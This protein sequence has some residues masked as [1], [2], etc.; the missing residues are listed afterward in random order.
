MNETNIYKPSNKFS[1]IGIIL[2]LFSM[3]AVGLILSWLYLILN[4]AI[5][6]IYLNVILAAGVSFGLGAIG[7]FFVKVYKI[8]APKLALIVSL[9]ALL[10]VNYGK[11]AIY[12]GRDYDKYMYE[13]LKDTK[14]TELNNMILGRD[15]A[16]PQT[17]EEAKAFLLNIQMSKTINIKAELTKTMKL[18][19]DS[20]EVEKTLSAITMLTNILGETAGDMMESLFG[21]TPEEILECSAKIKNSGNMSLYDYLYDFRGKQARTGLWL[22]A[23][24]GE[25]FSDIKNINSVG[26]WTIKSHRYGLGDNQGDNVSGIILWIVWAG[27]LAL[28]MIPAL[29]MIHKKAKYPFIE[30]EDDWAVEDKP[31]PAFVF[32]DIFPMEGADSAMVKG[33]IIRDPDYLLSMPII[34]VTQAVPEKYYYLTYC[35]SKYFDEIYIT[36]VFTT[37]VNPRKNQKK[38]T[39]VVTNLR[40][41]PDFLATLYGMFGF[42][43]PPL[44]QGVNRAEEMKKENAARQE[45]SFSGRP[46]SPTPP[47]ATGA[48]AIFDQPFSGRSAAREQPKQEESFAEQ[49]LKEERSSHTTSGD[50]DGI[51]TSSLNLDD[52]D[53]N[54]M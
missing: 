21:S 39:P 33:R 48:E 25:L 50:M 2:M 53:L 7:G 31:A 47:K 24:P 43:V 18:F 8:R 42:T 46:H 3:L 23:H 12:V 37:V 19:G 35:R 38:T 41:T 4:R 27:E 29:L 51:D 20:D 52:I 49:Q 32:A 28:L 13:D 10:M 36:V 17:E 54:H 14:V 40:V 5:P 15:F 16:L 22:M 9:I 26:R 6:L 30:A 1:V 44:C 34:T 45:E 11:W